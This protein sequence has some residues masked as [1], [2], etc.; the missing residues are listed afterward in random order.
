MSINGVMDKEYM[1]CVYKCTYKG[2][3][4]SYEKE[5]LPFVTTPMGPDV[6]MFSDL[7]QTEK[8]KYCMLSL[9]EYSLYES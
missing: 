7:S 3:L 8:D 9:H 4:Y 1:V 6:I 5:I 2:M